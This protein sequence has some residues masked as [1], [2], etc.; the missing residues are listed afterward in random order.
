MNTK[1][2]FMMDR[3]ELKEH[4][5]KIQNTVKLELENGTDIDEFL[6]KTTIFDEFENLIPD[7]EFSI[8][9]ITMLND[10]KSDVILEKLLDSIEE[11]IKNKNFL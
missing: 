11:S 3:K 10:F 7:E 8:F 4:L 5:Y 9:V 6:D 2:I 1:S